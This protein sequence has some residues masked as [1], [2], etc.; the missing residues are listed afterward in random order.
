MLRTEARMSHGA[1]ANG[2][3]ENKAISLNFTKLPD[4]RN[5]MIE[6]FLG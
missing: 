2:L 1:A 5:S 6:R 4:E 3:E